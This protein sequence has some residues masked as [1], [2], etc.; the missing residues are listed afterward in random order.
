[1]VCN[2]INYAGGTHYPGAGVEC[3]KRK[4]KKRKNIKE[5]GRT[6]KDKGKI[7]SERAN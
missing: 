5:K 3:K 1:M 2:R 7:L 4:V 6:R